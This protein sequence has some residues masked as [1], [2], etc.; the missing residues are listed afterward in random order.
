MSLVIILSTI[1]LTLFPTTF[2]TL[3]FGIISGIW[4][5]TKHPNSILIVDYLKIDE[6]LLKATTVY[7][8]FLEGALKKL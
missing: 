2:F 8:T 5:T 4:L 1:L 6:H 7:E 3:L